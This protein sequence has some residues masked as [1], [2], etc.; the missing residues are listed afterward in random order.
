MTT[1]ERIKAYRKAAKLTQTELGS[2]AGI[3]KSAVSMIENGK[4]EPSLKTL[5]IFADRLGVPV[6]ELIGG[7]EIDP[8][9]LSQAH[10]QILT[11]LN[12]LSDEQAEILLDVMKALGMAWE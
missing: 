7:K 3:K 10:I 11:A 8:G 9:E 5:K 2:A 6:E 4:T 1:G 12:Y